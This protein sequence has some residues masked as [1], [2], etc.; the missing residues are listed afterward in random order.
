V[1]APARVLV[2]GAAGM[3]GHRVWQACRDRFEAWATL[4]SAHGLPPE[5]YASPRVLRGIDVTD[6]ASIDAAFA[7]A[8]PGAVVNCVGIVKQVSAAA[9][10]VASLQVNALF[11]HLLAARCEQS[12]ARLIHL[13]T[14]CV[15]SGRKGRYI[16][17]DECDPPDL[18]GRTKLLGEP[19]GS[20]VLTLR[21]SMIGREIGTSH[22]L[23]EWFLSQR[24]GTVRGY[25]RAVFSGITTGRLASIIADVLDR[26]DNLTGVYHVSGD[27]IDKFDL[28]C[29]LNA[30][31]D[32]GVRIE[33]VDEPRIDRS[34]DSGR[35]R[36][37]TGW[38]PPGWNE[39]IAELTA[40]PTPYDRWRQG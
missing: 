8:K 34:L 33:P 26:F 32:A 35:F 22:G 5:L 29:R 14:D 20:N 7:A 13:S 1:T 4:R 6:A 40:D 16:E 9:D 27:P 38:A 2:F 11:P 17:L 18:Y 19:Q 39:M 31:F 30:A 37:A 24:G 28:L 21:T 25:R 15:F 10:A 12:G 23:L 3:L 36:E